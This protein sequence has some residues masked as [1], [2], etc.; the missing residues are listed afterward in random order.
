MV[1]LKK[2][3][4][5]TKAWKTSSGVLNM[6]TYPSRMQNRGHISKLRYWIP[7]FGVTFE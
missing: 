3:L 2:G 5:L 7:D 1:D 4:D 6:Y